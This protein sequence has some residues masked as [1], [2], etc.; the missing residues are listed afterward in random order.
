E[1]VLYPVGPGPSPARIAQCLVPT[2][3][4]SKLAMSIAVDTIGCTSY[5]VP[6]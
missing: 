2:G 1:Q 3:M 4:W 6:V 5:V